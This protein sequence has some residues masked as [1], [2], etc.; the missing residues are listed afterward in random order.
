MFSELENFFDIVSAAFLFLNCWFF[1]WDSKIIRGTDFKKIR[2]VHKDATHPNFNFFSSLIFHVFFT[3]V[4]C[5]RWNWRRY[6]SIAAI[7]IDGR[8]LQ[9]TIRNLLE[10]FWLLR[11]NSWLICE[12]TFYL[13]VSSFVIFVSYSK[14]NYFH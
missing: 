2:W 4:S 11:K 13:T 5:T 14:T 6:I 1:K 12:I 9:W 7:C 8:N 10:H 3:S